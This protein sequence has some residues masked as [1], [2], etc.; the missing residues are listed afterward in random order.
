MLEQTLAASTSEKATCRTAALA[1]APS[2]IIQLP[3]SKPLSTHEP[4]RWPACQCI[5][6]DFFHKAMTEKTRLGAI[7]RPH[8]ISGGQNI[9]SQV[10]GLRSVIARLRKNPDDTPSHS[11]VLI[12]RGTGCRLE[13]SQN[14]LRIV[15][16][17]IV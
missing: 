8:Q 4:F 2:L 1:S 15:K 16:G 10:M 11:N 9:D 6:L 17:G 14:H 12:V 7:I 3:C 13:L 5:G